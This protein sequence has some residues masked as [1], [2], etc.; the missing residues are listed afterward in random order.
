MAVHKQQT[1]CF[2]EIQLLMVIKLILD[3]YGLHLFLCC[4][5]LIVTSRKA[6]VVMAST[7]PY[8]KTNTGIR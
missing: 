6:P 8:I 5:V 1:V 3:Y 7:V 4:R 2:P